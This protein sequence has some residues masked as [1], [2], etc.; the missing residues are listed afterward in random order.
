MPHFEHRLNCI[1]ILDNHEP[2][3]ISGQVKLMS[4]I[5]TADDPLPELY[6][7]FAEIDPAEKR[8]LLR[9]AVMQVL[10]S[11]ELVTLNNIK[12]GHEIWFGD[13][14]Y[15]LY[16]ADKILN[17]YNWQMLVIESDANLRA[18]GNGINTLINDPAF[19]TFLGNIA[20]F[21]SFAVNPSVT[22]G[23]A[24]AKYVIGQVATLFA[25]NKDD[26]IGIVYQSF[27]RALDYP[28][29]DRRAFNIP[30]MSG[31]MFIDYRIFG[32]D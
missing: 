4:F 25:N 19:D 16:T 11:K 13:T 20:E 5:T 2:L 27:Y 10:S 3:G 31:N 1:K 32:E 15:S 26:Q 12:D 17:S 7:Y 24:V 21:A 9:A 28:S 30:D 8:D 29:L 18:I 23:I 6:E 22:L 14:G